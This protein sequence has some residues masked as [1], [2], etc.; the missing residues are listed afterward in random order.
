MLK[1]C[2]SPGALA[3]GLYYPSGE[4]ASLA[5]LSLCFLLLPSSPCRDSEWETVHAGEG[6]TVRGVRWGGGG[7]LVKGLLQMST[8]GW[9]RYKVLLVLEYIRPNV[10]GPGGPPLVS[11]CEVIFSALE[12]HH[13][14]PCQPLI[15]LPPVQRSIHTRSTTGTSPGL[16]HHLVLPSWTFPRTKRSKPLSIQPPPRPDLSLDLEEEE[17]ETKM[18]NF[19]KVF[20]YLALAT[21]PFASAMPVPGFLGF[22]TPPTTH[23]ATTTST[24]ASPP[25]PGLDEKFKVGGIAKEEEEDNSSSAWSSENKRQVMQSSTGVAVV[26]D[27]DTPYI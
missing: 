9:L 4:R 11:L 25:G 15:F 27:D 20:F 7:I 5:N 2:I 22:L 6:L 10:H 16:D 17:E 24:M 21:V 3:C 8:T 18:R 26:V 12:H 14:H 19:G 23:V 13:N 1:G